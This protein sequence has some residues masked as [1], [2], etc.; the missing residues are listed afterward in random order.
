MELLPEN[1]ALFL[2]IFETVKHQIRMQPG[3]DGLEL[4]RS[5]GDG[6]LNIWTI[7]LWQSEDDLNNYRTSDLFMKTWSA[8]KPLFSAKTKAWSLTNTDTLP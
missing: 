2:S 7:S 1:E 4:L 5:T 6:H 3:C 8:V